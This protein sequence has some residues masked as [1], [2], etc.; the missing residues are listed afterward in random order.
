MAVSTCVFS[1]CL[2]LPILFGALGRFG[3]ISSGW[4]HGGL[5]KPIGHH[6]ISAYTEELEHSRWLVCHVFRCLDVVASIFCGG[7]AFVG[8]SPNLALP[9]RVGAL[10]A[11]GRLS[12]GWDMMDCGSPFVTTENF[13]CTEELKHFRWVDMSCLVLFLVTV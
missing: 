11:F 5:R 6:G 9:T 8:V 4:G 13:A 10:G 12:Y 2:A 1:S 7:V 3:G